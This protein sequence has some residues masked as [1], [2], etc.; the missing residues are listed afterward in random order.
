MSFRLFIYYCALCGGWAAFVAFLLVQGLGLRH[1]DYPLLRTVVVSGLLGVLLA[2]GIGG[3]DALLNAVG[4]Q[5]VARVGVSL[6]VG[7]AGGLIGGLAGGM[8]YEMLSL[9]KFVGWAL[10]G[11]AIGASIAAFDV[12]TAWMTGQPA[13][14]ALRKMRNGLVGGA[15]G[16]VIGGLFFVFLENSESLTRTSLA[17]GFVILG[18]SI[19]LLIGLVMV[20]FKEAWVRI[21]NG[22]RSGREMMLTKGEST[23][24]RAETCDIGLF[25]DNAVERTHA[26]ILLQ[27]NCYVLVD[28][29]TRGGTFVNEERLTQARVLASGDLIRI[30]DS[31]LRFGERR[32][33]H[34]EA[35]AGR[36]IGDLAH[37]SR[38]QQGDRS[39]KLRE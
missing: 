12:G 3:V 5:R 6:G 16:G 13:A 28:A 22:R 35:G 10:V 1:G 39:T 25:G 2:G 30:G 24:G 34:V 36:Q 4:R 19:G 23:I 7:L 9:P 37:E 21:E 29:G 20:I 15:L 18:A 11:T 31:L 33:E 8:L 26:R 14:T 17:L 32:K 27:G 38:G